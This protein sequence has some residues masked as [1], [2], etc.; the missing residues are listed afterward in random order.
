MNV[1]FGTEIGTSKFGSLHQNC[2]IVIKSR[3]ISLELATR[4]GYVP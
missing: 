4:Q 1:C 2:F 3:S